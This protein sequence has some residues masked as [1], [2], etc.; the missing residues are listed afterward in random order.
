MKTR[1]VHQITVFS[2]LQSTNKKTYE[3]WLMFELYWTPDV[4]LSLRI[5]LYAD[6]SIDIQINIYIFPHVWILRKI[7]LEY[8]FKTKSH[9]KNHVDFL[10]YTG[11]P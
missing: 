9:I 2:L 5:I 1:P 3:Y 4:T 11:V 6:I 8:F 10:I 7:I